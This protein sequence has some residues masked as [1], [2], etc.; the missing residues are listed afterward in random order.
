MQKSEVRI[1]EVHDRFV[2]I[3][4]GRSKRPNVHSA[5]PQ[6]PERD[7]VCPFDNDALLPKPTLYVDGPQRHWRVKVV[8]N[9]FPV[10]S[11]DNPK[12]YGYQEVVIETPE[13]N[14]ELADLSVSQIVNV[15]KAFVA[16]SKALTR[17]RKIRYVLIFK[18]QGGK[19]G[20]SIAHSHSQIFS[21]SFIPPH[22]IDK[23]TKAQSW[24]IE[25]GDCYYC[26]LIKREM[27]GPRR[28]LSDRHV[29]AFTPYASIY[30]YEAWIIPHRHVD[31]LTKLNGPELVSLARALKRILKKVNI[32]KL[33]Y[34]FYLHQ[35][36]TDKDE[37]FYLRVAPRRDVWAGIEMGSRL[38]INTVAPETAAKFYRS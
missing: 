9:K 14:R 23:L 17:D 19:A 30:N 22:I 29:A 21:A 7:A 33:P 11:R 6:E 37:H 16:R 36:V 25:H 8:R 12:A 38:I 18:N 2:I 10:L 24:R 13:H 20:A 1:D 31:N 15:L 3:A 4:P 34:N 35:A 26:D 28:I 27:R 32:L 5:Y